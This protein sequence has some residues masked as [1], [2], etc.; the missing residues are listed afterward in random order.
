MPYEESITFKTY[1]LLSAPVPLADLIENRKN[2]QVSTPA[3]PDEKTSSLEL[4]PSGDN[5]SVTFSFHR[6]I[7]VPAGNNTQP[8]A[9]HTLFLN[10]MNTPSTVSLTY[11]Y[12]DGRTVSSHR[13]TVHPRAKRQVVFKGMSCGI[14]VKLTITFREHSEEPLILK[15]AYISYATYDLKMLQRTLEQNPDS[16]KPFIEDNS[17]E[18][19]EHVLDI[20]HLLNSPE[21]VRILAEYLGDRRAG[22]YAY[23]HL[24]SLTPLMKKYAC[25]HALSISGRHIPPL[26]APL[27]RGSPGWN[28]SPLLTKFLSES[29]S[30][31][32]REAAVITISEKADYALVDSYLSLLNDSS[33]FIKLLAI[34]ALTE[35]RPVG[36]F[37]K[38]KGFLE[39]PHLSCAAVHAIGAVGSIK[40]VEP[41]LKAAANPYCA[42]AAAQYLKDFNLADRFP[43]LNNL[44]LSRAPEV[45]EAAAFLFG[46]TIAKHPEISG[47]A[48]KRLLNDNSPQVR[49]RAAFSF[50]R[51]SSPEFLPFLHQ[52]L[53]DPDARVVLQ[54][55]RAIG[56][57]ANYS[58]L[59]FL[60]ACYEQTEPAAV[61]AIREEIGRMRGTEY[62]PPSRPEIPFRLTEYSVKQAPD[63]EV[64]FT[65]NRSIPL[66]P[67]PAPLPEEILSK[68]PLTVFH[69]PG[70]IEPCTFCLFTPEKIV[71][72][73]IRITDFSSPQGD[74]ISRNDITLFIEK[75]EGRGRILEKQQ[76]LLNVE[77]GDSRRI[78]AFFDLSS[79]PRPGIYRGSV[80]IGH[81]LRT[82][83]TI[84]LL[85]WKKEMSSEHIFVLPSG[86]PLT[87]FEK[88][89][90]A[91]SFPS[92]YQ[93]IKVPFYEDISG[94]PV[95]SQVTARLAAVDGPVFLNIGPVTSSEY[96]GSPDS[97]AYHIAPIHTRRLVKSILHIQSFCRANSLRFPVYIVNTNTELKDSDESAVI[98]SLLSLARSVTGASTLRF[99][100]RKELASS[101]A[102]FS[103]QTS[104]ALDL[105]MR[106]Q[107]HNLNRELLLFTR[108]DT[109]AKKVRLR[110]GLYGWLTESDGHVFLYNPYIYGSTQK[111]DTIPLPL[112]MAAEGVKDLRL[113]KKLETL[114]PAMK[115]A[116]KK[117]ERIKIILKMEELLFKLKH[118]VTPDWNDTV[119]EQVSPD[120]VR[121]FLINSLLLLQRDITL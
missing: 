11:A 95:F 99:C 92:A 74:V 42:H 76:F 87:P 36:A 66:S 6:G 3:V 46:C 48:L 112:I 64:L 44:A 58:S 89:V 1:D 78:W 23:R 55:V 102:R 113:L 94:K 69:I 31:S 68:D 106:E 43:A 96:R 79:E 114:L 105:K 50:A 5:S 17:T 67:C 117:A 65:R 84:H 115:A 109:P 51:A 29:V 33:D 111:R 27:L 72:K 59:P 20:L 121:R 91:A 49:S 85:P 101:A 13:I 80:R 54:A 119:W 53:E 40:T 19:M 38:M 22:P 14:P 52:A 61:Y 88:K 98:D 30:A 118:G 2:I 108:S 26:A 100:T 56:Q 10:R 18:D 62:H 37:E 9:L 90:I 21:S 7:P 57:T 93:E 110:L 81:S 35:L 83:V 104:G 8:R 45:R 103:V 4:I 24:E 71:K 32:V 34:R 73:R 28:I 70:Y 15:S 86:R 60:V 97:C 75:E 120:T 116:E 39:H 63:K 12:R 16:W 107:L 25:E 41:L 82:D 77:A 47:G